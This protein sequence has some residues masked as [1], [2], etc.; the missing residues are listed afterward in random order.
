MNSKTM[1]STSNILNYIFA[2]SLV[3]VN[4]R[5]ISVRRISLNILPLDI[6]LLVG[7]IINSLIILVIE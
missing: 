2:P 3:D 7:I 4:G 6:L 1:N 5:I